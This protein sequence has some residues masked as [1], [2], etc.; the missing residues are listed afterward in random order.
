MKAIMLMTILGLTFTNTALAID[1]SGVD[2]NLPICDSPS[3][4]W[5]RTAASTNGAPMPGEV[6]QEA[7]IEVDLNNDGH[8]DRVQGISGRDTSGQRDSGAVAI[9]YGTAWGFYE[10]YAN[11]TIHQDSTYMNGVAEAGDRFGAAL[12]AGDF[13]GDDDIELAIGAPGEAIGSTSGAGL[14][15]VVRGHATGPIVFYNQLWHQ[16]SDGI[17]HSPGVNDGFGSALAVGDFDRDGFDDLAIG[18]PGEM[19]GYGAV[20]VLYG[21]T[22][23][24][25]SRDQWLYQ[26][27][28]GVSGSPELGDRFGA[29]VSA[30]DFNDDGYADL[31]VGAPGEALGSKN[32]AGMVTVFWGRSSGLTGSGSQKFHQDV[33]G[34]QGVA[35]AGDRFGA[36]LMVGDF[37]G[38]DIVDLA[39]A[40]SNEVV[41]GTSRRGYVNVL[42]G[43][44][45][46][47]SASG[48]PGWS[49]AK[50][51]A[52]EEMMTA[53]LG[54]SCSPNPTSITIPGG[55]EGISFSEM[56]ANYH[57]EG[58]ELYRDRTDLEDGECTI[59]RDP[60]DPTSRLGTVFCKDHD[61]ATSQLIYGGC[62]ARSS[63]E[64]S[65]GVGFGVYEV[66]FTA[67]DG[68]EQTWTFQGPSADVCHEVTPERYCLGG[69][70]SIISAEAT[71]IDADGYGVTVGAAAGIG[72]GYNIPTIED[73]VLTAQFSFG[74]GTFGVSIPL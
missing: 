7:W 46:G 37:T 15:S 39:I 5:S 68:T 19:Y 29:A 72:I 69:Q 17:K 8:L 14:V 40:S 59:V 25:T 33:S 1:H 42:T 41:G 70:A 21:S 12:A 74:M 48:D 36:A 43:T 18:V 62:D 56:Q 58:W 45:N 38:D 6:F 66:A 47:L 23:G 30:G 57:D 35:E 32:E 60:D 10:G 73:D 16:D 24:L 4:L 64:M 34:V 13:D 22:W 61:H 51:A 53:L 27:T 65:C 26:G 2:F 49:Y 50:S 52:P 71:V 55:S 63:E 20:Q 67:P 3:S 54:A 28:S 11:L 31:A 44:R 9:Q